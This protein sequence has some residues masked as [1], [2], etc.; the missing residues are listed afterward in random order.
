MAKNA[1]LIFLLFTFLVWMLQYTE[2]LILL[3]TFSVQ[4]NLFQKHLFLHQL[5]H[6]I[7]KCCSL[8][9]KFSTWKLQ[10]VQSAQ[11]QQ[12]YKVHLSSYTTWDIWICLA[13]T[14]SLVTEY[15]SLMEFEY[16]SSFTGGWYCKEAER[17]TYLSTCI[18]HSAFSL[19]FLILW[20]QRF[21]SYQFYCCDSLTALFSIFSLIHV[22]KE[23]F[24]M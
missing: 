18:K 7:T 6:N 2:T 22:Q 15:E 14:N 8:N 13:L 11:Q 20:K 12:K 4:V 19:F 23:F 10:V 21:F 24:I 3:Q 9:Y 16:L 5:N 17:N 1:I